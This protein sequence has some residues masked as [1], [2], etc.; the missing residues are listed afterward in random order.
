MFFLQLYTTLFLVA[1]C[2]K[3]YNPQACFLAIV[4]PLALV[5]LPTINNFLGEQRAT[6]Q[7]VRRTQENILSSWPLLW[8]CGILV[9]MSFCLTSIGLYVNNPHATF[10]VSNIFMV[11]L[12]IFNFTFFSPM[13]SKVN[14]YT[15]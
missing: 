11:G 13:I 2:L 5:I 3:V 8:L 9:L 6:E 7:A 10:V 15:D 1:F 4:G 14:A 12:L